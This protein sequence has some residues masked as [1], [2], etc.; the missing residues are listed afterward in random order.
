[1]LS[2]ETAVGSYPVAAVGEMRRIATEAETSPYYRRLAPEV[3][4]GEFDRHTEAI[5][6][7]TEILAD[8]L[9]AKAVLV[10]AHNPAKAQLISKRQSKSASD[11]VLLRSGNMASL[12]SLLGRC[13]AD[14][15]AMPDPLDLVES[16]VREAERAQLLNKG[17]SVVVL[18][19][20]GKGRANTVRVLE[21]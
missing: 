15:H 6:T 11:R 5:T 9:E 2:G 14:D 8:R 3:L 18:L 17:D 19:G 21:V 10:F 4:I 13:A 12:R 7:A 1:M 16:G 20:F